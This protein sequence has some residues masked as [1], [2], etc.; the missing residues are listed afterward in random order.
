[1]TFFVNVDDAKAKPR[2]LWDMSSDE[3]YKDPGRPVE[4]T[5][6]NGQR[7][8]HMDGNAI[9]L[10][11]MGSSLEGDRPFLDRFD[12]PTR[13][14]ERL[15]RSDK[16]ALEFFLA[17]TAANNRTFLTWHQ[18]PADPPNAFV[19]TLGDALASASQHDGEAIVASTAHAVT[20]IPDPTPA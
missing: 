5:L 8:M 14:S 12:L 2:L 10:D 3:R 15:F 11:G 6:P 17:F 16:H 1:R 7:V 20:H 9:Y 18:S 4:H 19:R 13:K